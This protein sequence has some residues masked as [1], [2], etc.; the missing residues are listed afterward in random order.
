MITNKNILEIL[1]FK[2][3]IQERLLKSDVSVLELKKLI[4]NY[5]FPNKIKKKIIK[6]AIE[7]GKICL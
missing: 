7:Q 3:L 4:D 1:D 2:N 6:K 5:S